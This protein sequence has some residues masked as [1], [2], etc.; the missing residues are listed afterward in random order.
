MMSCA[1]KPAQRDAD[2]EFSKTVRFAVHRQFRPALRIAV[3][4]P[5]MKPCYDVMQHHLENFFPEFFRTLQ[6]RTLYRGLLGFELRVGPVP[7]G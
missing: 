5:K 7:K 3:A 2:Q 4:R 1:E 6:I